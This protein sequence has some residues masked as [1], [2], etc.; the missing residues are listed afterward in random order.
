MFHVKHSA[1][2]ASVRR[3]GPSRKWTP[4]LIDLRLEPS[5]AELNSTE[6]KYVE[7]NRCGIVVRQGHPDVRISM[8]WRRRNFAGPASVA[9]PYAAWLGESPIFHMN[10]CFAIAN[11]SR[12]T[13]R[14]GLRRRGYEFR[15]ELE[16]WN[17]LPAV[18][19]PMPSYRNSR[20]EA[21]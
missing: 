5:R 21:S 16:S 1:G 2:Y 12:E 7:L 4:G 13:V 6:F 14:S 18:G 8:H 10:A 11:V 3:V 15:R 9:T 20:A 17:P 19:E